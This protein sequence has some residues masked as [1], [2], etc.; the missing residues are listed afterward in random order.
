MEDGTT[1]IRGQLDLHMFKGR[2]S[3]LLVKE[4]TRC[5]EC[6]SDNIF[7]ILDEIGDLERTTHRTCDPHETCR[8][9]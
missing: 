7:H 2:Y 8:A 1:Y 6:R 9:V 5:V 3:S 4:L